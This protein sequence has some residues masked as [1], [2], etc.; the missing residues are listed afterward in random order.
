MLGTSCASYPERTAEALHAFQSGRFNQALATYSDPD[1][2]GSAFLSGA[3]AGTV[4]LTAG[5]WDQ[6]LL[7]FG[8]AV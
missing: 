8:R 2:V 1:E 5:D 7:H 6:A 4:M 3:E